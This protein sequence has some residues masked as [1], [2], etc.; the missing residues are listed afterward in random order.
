MRQPNLYHRVF[1][2]LSLNHFP[3]YQRCT[4][5]IHGDLKNLSLAKSSLA[6]FVLEDLLTVRTSL[7]EKWLLVALPRL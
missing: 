7:K 3:P 5:L 2:H 4:V 6:L 1:G